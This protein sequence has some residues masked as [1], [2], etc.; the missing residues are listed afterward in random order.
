[1]LRAG[2]TRWLA[3]QQEPDID[4]LVPKVEQVVRAYVICKERL[5]AVQETLGL[6]LQPEHGSADKT[7]RGERP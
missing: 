2:G 6:H 4:H 5:D 3:G 7:A 1:V